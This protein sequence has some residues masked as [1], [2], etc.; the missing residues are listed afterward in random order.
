MREKSMQTECGG[1]AEIPAIGSLR[2]EDW[3]MFEATLDCKQTN[4]N[5]KSLYKDK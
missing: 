2:Q 3:C 4:T 1:P 5:G